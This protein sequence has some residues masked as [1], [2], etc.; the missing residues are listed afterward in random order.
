MQIGGYC[1][2]LVENEGRDQGKCNRDSKKSSDSG[3]FGHSRV[4]LEWMWQAKTK[5]S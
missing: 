4:L 5:R 2:N 1:K 3:D